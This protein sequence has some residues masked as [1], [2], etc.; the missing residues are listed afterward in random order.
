[1]GRIAAS[2]GTFNGGLFF[3]LL[4]G[5]PGRAEIRMCSTRKAKT[6]G[7]LQTFVLKLLSF[8]VMQLRL[9]IPCAM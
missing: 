8:C 7:Y 2:E 9:D 3:L 1:M 5:I 6:R 4:C